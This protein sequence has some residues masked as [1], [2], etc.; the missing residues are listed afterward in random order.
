MAVVVLAFSISRLPFGI[1]STFN[2]LI[3][4]G[5]WLLVYKAVLVVLST[6]FHSPFLSNP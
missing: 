4:T 3:A 6:I 2:T 1:G 5:F